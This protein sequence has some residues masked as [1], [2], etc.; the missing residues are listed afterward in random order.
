M[1]VRESGEIP[2]LPR[3]CKRHCY[4]SVKPLFLY[5]K[6]PVLVASQ[7]TGPAAGVNASSEG[8]ETLI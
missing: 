4:T 1:D 6:A 3:N 5:G 8:K 7:D 2:L